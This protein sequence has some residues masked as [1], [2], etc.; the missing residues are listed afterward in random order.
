ME[1]ELGIKYAKLQRATQMKGK[2]PPTPELVMELHAKKVEARTYALA[3][4]PEIIKQF[5]LNT[6]SGGLRFLKEKDVKNVIS[7][8]RFTKER[9]VSDSATIAMFPDELEAVK[10]AFEKCRPLP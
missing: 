1:E 10:I 5:R 3:V 8:F 7:L 4:K 6:S 9:G 2:W